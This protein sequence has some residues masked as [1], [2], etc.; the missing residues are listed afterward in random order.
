MPLIEILKARWYV[1]IAILAI[2][3]FLLNWFGV[4]TILG[5]ESFSTLTLYESNESFVPQGNTISLTEE[6]FKEFPQLASIIRDKTT[7]PTVISMEGIRSYDIPFTSD[8]YSLFLAR[9]WSNVNR[10]EVDKPFPHNRIFEYNGKYYEF[11]LPA[12]H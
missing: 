2:L 10:S 1:F 6:D 7:K 9:Y 3:I 8:E 5:K 11:E 4:I 12:I